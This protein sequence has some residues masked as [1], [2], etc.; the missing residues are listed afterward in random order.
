MSLKGDLGYFHGSIRLKDLCMSFDQP[1]LIIGHR[2]AAGLAPENTLPGFER[3][4]ALG[5][6]A[7]ELDVHEHSGNLVVIH[8][9][10]VER[11]TDGSGPLASYSFDA[12]RALDAGNGNAIP[13]LDEVL[14][15]MRGARV[16]VE[17]KG[18]GT[19]T[20]ASK[21]IA[22]FPDID[23]LV[24][25][26]DHGELASFRA[27]DDRTKVAPLFSRWREGVGEI[28]ARVN[29]WSVNLSVRATRGDRVARLRD[30][31]FRVLCYTVNTREE[32]HQLRELGVAGVFTDYPNR[33]IPDL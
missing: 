7:V 25:S 19:A 11:T 13:V 6:H 27:L 28:A 14:A 30:A 32:M 2:G 12:L 24:S 29:A 31:G 23:F 9:D 4:R 3:A 8:D 22:R 26:F 10:T 21:H 17:L 20:L 33:L 18:P 5:V 15:Q 1:F 16:N